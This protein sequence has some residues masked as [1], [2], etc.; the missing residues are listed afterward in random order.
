MIRR[1]EIDGDIDA[2]VV[3][4]TSRFM[5]HVLKAK[6]YKARLRSKGIVVIACDQETTDDASGHLME[7]FYE[8]MDQYESEA[9]GARTKAAM[10][11]N[12]K[13]GFFNWSRAP[14]GFKVEKVELQRDVVKG[15]LVIEPGEAN[16]LREVFRSYIEMAGAKATAQALN[17]AGSLR[18]GRPWSKDDVL[19]ALE[20][21]AA[22]G[23]YFWGKSNSDRLRVDATHW[24]PMKVEPIVSEEVFALAAA[25]RKEREPNPSKGRTPSSP[26]LLAG[27]VRCGA[28]GAAYT[29]QTGKSG[30]HRYYQCRSYS[31]VGKAACA[32]YAVPTHEIEDAVLSNLADNLFTPERSAALVDALAKESSSTSKRVHEERKL[33]QKELNDVERKIKRWTEDFERSDARPDDL[34]AE[35]VHELQARRRQLREKLDA[36]VELAPVPQRL[37]SPKVLQKFNADVR[38]LFM[39]GNRALAKSYLTFLVDNIVLNRNEVT[40]KAKSFAALKMMATGVKDENSEEGFITPPAVLA[41]DLKWLRHLGS[42][43]GPCD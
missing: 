13:R 24:V 42:N 41:S 43:Q 11:E 7:S 22:I 14:F 4:W 21:T 26:L 31:R 20:E 32:G 12:A 23:T 35:R 19:R 1:A 16:T 39:G 15:R 6:A 29:L 37:R 33:W 36:A 34:G 2:I 8:M 17:A 40:I 30:K 10:R 27:L 25:V 28:C 18:R 9:N 3:R 5:R 38:A